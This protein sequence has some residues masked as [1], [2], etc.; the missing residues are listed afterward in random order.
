MNLEAE[1]QKGGARLCQGGRLAP[2]CSRA[3]GDTNTFGSPL[4]KCLQLHHCPMEAGPSC[5]ADSPKAPK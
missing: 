5:A 4:A 3:A 2:G 1:G